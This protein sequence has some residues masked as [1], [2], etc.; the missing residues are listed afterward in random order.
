MTPLCLTG[1][2]V[3]LDGGIIDGAHGAAHHF[4]GQAIFR[5]I[6]PVPKQVPITFFFTYYSLFCYIRLIRK[7]VLISLLGAKDD[8]LEGMGNSGIFCHVRV[9]VYRDRNHDFGRF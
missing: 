7:Q 4:F 9:D 6:Q 1:A 8:F 2:S 5:Y 3:Y